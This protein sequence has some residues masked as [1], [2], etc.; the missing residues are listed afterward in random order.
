MAYKDYESELDLLIDKVEGSI[1]K[2]WTELVAELEL[3]CHEDTLRKSFA[4]GRY[5]GYKVAKYYR[6]KIENGIYEEDELERINEQR[7]ELYKERCKL[8][9]ANREKRN[10]L[11][12][13]ARFENLLDVLRDSIEQ[14]EHIKF[15]TKIMDNGEKKSAILQLSDWHIGSTV[16]TQWN[17]YSI[18][19]AKIRVTELTNKIKGYILSF[20]I[21]DLMIEINGDMI[22]GLINVGANIQ[23][24]ED[25]V[26]SI[27][28]V[29]NM[30]ADM[31]NELKPY[32]LSMKV[33]TT[34]GNHGRLDPNKKNSVLGQ[35]FE[36]LIPEF[37]KLMTSNVPII[38]SQGLDF[39]KYEFNDK[40]IMLSHGNNDKLTTCIQDFVQVYKQVPTEIH[41]GHTHSFKD[42][43]M[44]NI[45]ITVNGS[46][47]GSDEYALGLRYT[48]KPSQ[49][50]IVYG[51]DR[52]VVEIIVE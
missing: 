16:D 26:D 5:S 28:I 10:V 50:L 11:R 15:G 24:E 6:N 25:A 32:V 52:M 4:V 49:N 18:D 27:T 20:N 19:T 29:S 23:A 3:N 43:N 21:T 38:T 47:K 41:L 34:L 35:N 9:D 33:V 40:V 7:D 39:M 44:S 31:I 48:T 22:E 37:L 36:K 17:E 1:D 2:D 12:S 14:A 8:Q 42:I 45:Y 46:L 13:E 51:K 30:L